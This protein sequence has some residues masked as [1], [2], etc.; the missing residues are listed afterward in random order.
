MS[1]PNGGL[2]ARFPGAERFRV[3]ASR[4]APRLQTIPSQRTIYTIEYDGFADFPQ[5]PI[6]FLSDL[7]AFLGI[8]FEL[9]GTYPSLAATQI[10]SALFQLTQYGG[11]PRMTTVLSFFPPR[12]CRCWTPVRA[13]RDHR[14]P[15]SRTWC[16]RIC[17]YLVDWGY[18]E[19]RPSGWSHRAG[20]MCRPRSGC[21][22]RRAA[23][24]ATSW[25]DLVS[26]T[27]QGIGAFASDLSAPRYRRRCPPCRCRA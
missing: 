20:R 22:R 13:I 15:A 27:Q 4:S 14:E 19:H 6:D 7:N 3:W 1:N 2:F 9:H 26:G 17:G 16:N 5:Y 8:A 10:A 12:I 11:R 25:P 18:G 24:T 23:T 21:C